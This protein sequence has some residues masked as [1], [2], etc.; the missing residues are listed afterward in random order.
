MKILIII[1]TG[2]TLSVSNHCQAQTWKEWFRQKKTQKKYLIQ[3][4]VA[5]QVYLG[6]VK[7]G[8]KIVHQGLDLIGDIKEGKFDLHKDYFASLDAV[9]PAI[10]N[11]AKVAYILALQQLIHRDI[12]ALYEDSRNNENYTTGETGYL[13]QVYANLLEECDASVDDLTMVVTTDELQM[14]DNERLA[15]I[16]RIFDDMRNMVAFTRHFGNG[17]R[18]LALQRYREQND[19]D[20]IGQLHDV[21]P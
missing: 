15:R 19:V 5:L 14:K 2:I 11:S 12:Q 20:V 1:I 17:A 3:Q 10:G 18:L 9:N 13:S 4:V 8:Y 21:Q 6:Y 7:K 16:D